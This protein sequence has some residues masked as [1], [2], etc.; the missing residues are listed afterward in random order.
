MRCSF[1]WFAFFQIHQISFYDK[2]TGVVGIRERIWTTHKVVWVCLYMCAHVCWGSRGGCTAY[3]KCAW[4]CLSNR[5]KMWDPLCFPLPVLM[6]LPTL[7]TALSVTAV[8]CREHQSWKELGD[9]NVSGGCALRAKS[10]GGPFKRKDTQWG[11]EDTGN[12]W[13]MVGQ[14]GT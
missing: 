13:R 7:K 1:I 11:E 14:L 6:Q 2:Q 5:G 9:R 12:A 8:Q 3:H 4:R 10:S